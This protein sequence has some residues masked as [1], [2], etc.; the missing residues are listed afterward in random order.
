[1]STSVVGAVA[2]WGSLLTSKCVAPL[3]LSQMIRAKTES[4]QQTVKRMEKSMEKRLVSKTALKSRGVG[5]GKGKPLP[6]AVPSVGGAALPAWMPPDC[7][8]SCI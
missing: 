5:K 8:R 2:G 7:W 3:Q 6:A 4:M 1:M